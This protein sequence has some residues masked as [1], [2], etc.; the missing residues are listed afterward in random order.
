MMPPATSRA[1]TATLQRMIGMA[2]GSY[3]SSI[4]VAGDMVSNHSLYLGE[5]FGAR[6]KTEG[7]PTSDAKRSHPAQ[8]IPRIRS[9]YDHGGAAWLFE[10]LKSAKRFISTPCEVVSF[11]ERPPL[12]Q[13]HAF[14]I[15]KPYARER[16]EKDKTK[17]WRAEDEVYYG[18]SNISRCLTPP[19]KALATLPPN[20]LVLVLDDAALG[21]WEQNQSTLLHYLAQPQIRW[22]VVKLSPLVEDAPLWGAVSQ[23][24]PDKLIALV[25]AYKLRR[26]SVD[27]TK[28]LSWQRAVKDLRA[29]WVQKHRVLMSLKACRHL[30]ILFSADGALWLNLSEQ[31][32]PNVTLIY[33]PA[34][35]EGEWVDRREGE[36]PGYSA[37]I[38]AAIVLGLV[39]LPAAAKEP[40]LSGPILK[41]LGAVRMLIDVGHGPEG[42]SLPNFPAKDL[43][44]FLTTEDDPN[45]EKP[46]RKAPKDFEKYRLPFKTTEVN[47]CD[48]KTLPLCSK[49]AWGFVEALDSKLGSKR[50]EELLQRAARIVRKGLRCLVHI[51][52]A[53][54]GK[55]CT[56]DVL[57]IEMLRSQ[58]LDF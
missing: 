43:I 1:S 58:H 37:L 30:V 20:P 6:N 33:D 5:G 32:H 44:K 31:E 39:A 54:F 28:G 40:D 42:Q 10:F 23:K 48:D 45:T 3:R 56:I 21:F 24:F 53:R 13:H 17:V 25:S 36:V 46:F 16:S 49:Q 7:P 4:L 57:E 18:S 8:Q 47:W 51:P 50:S 34:G 22:I 15:F 55:L 41:G 27:I 19:S 29:A 52:H 14:S 12:S 11:I 38:T 26:R 2:P 9:V 35:A